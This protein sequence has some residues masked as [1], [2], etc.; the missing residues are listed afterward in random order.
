MTSRGKQA[1]LSAANAVVSIPVPKE[2][3]LAQGR[4]FWLEQRPQENGRTTLMG[5]GSRGR[6]PRDLTPGQW[7]L[8][9]RIHG[10][11]GGSYTVN[12]KI[13]VFVHDGDRC[14][15]R[16]D[17]ESGLEPGLE[18]VALGQPRQLT[19]PGEQGERT[20]S[21]GLID[22]ARD[23]WIGVMEQGGEDFWVAVPLEGGEPKT[24]HRPADFCGY[25]VLSP[26]GTHL[27][28]IEWQQPHMSWERSSLWL[29][30]FDTDGSLAD[31]R[32]IAGSD[33]TS[34]VPISVFQ[35]L[36]AGDD[37]VVA[38]D[39]SGW[40]NLE[41]LRDAE[42]LAIGAEP[43]WQP[44]LPMEAEFGAPQWVHGL[45]TT[46]WDGQQLVAAACRQGQWEL[47]KVPVGPET[48]PGEVHGP[49]VPAAWQPLSLPL[50]DIAGICAENGTLVAI[51]SGPTAPAGRLEVNLHNLNWSHTPTESAVA[52]RRD[53]QLPQALW[54]EGAS[55]QPTQA[56]FHPPEGGRHPG[57]P[58]L[59]RGHSGPT[60]VAR[61]GLS[62]AI[63]FWTSR[64]WGVLDV[65]YGGST[66]FG[67]AYRQRLDG[68]WGVV[69][70]ADLIAAAQA[71]LAE[72]WAD[73]QRV[74]T[75]GGSAAGFTVLSALAQTETFKAGACRYPVTDLA[76]MVKVGHRF[77]AHY[78]DG[79]VGPWPE[80]RDV[81]W[82]R[83]PLNLVERIRTPLILFHGLQDDVVPASQSERLALELTRRGMPVELHLFADEGHGFRASA[84]Q[85][86][87]LE[88]T[89]AFFRRHLK[90]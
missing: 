17:L 49:S 12:G 2:P 65:N 85:A 69:D 28:W 81:Y 27:A 25:P 43:H 67:R 61:T 56:W 51:A 9:S 55:G 11:G 46:A 57:A 58:L 7:N 15:W 18:V 29:G 37:L 36:W 82:S 33:G 26:S 19:A 21:D 34:P 84:V 35:P 38:N 70:V 59:V 88:A 52:P 41:I 44:L 14:L 63:Q 31:I 39:R 6:P 8:R 79:L 50:N 68:Q 45:R 87:V 47:G 20:F 72:G 30:R 3:L 32:P 1:P 77:E 10:Y 13:A 23:R 48:S 86:Q 22:R 5:C 53:Q 80:A 90:L 89:E 16:L 64:G 62:A 74:A 83:S 73:P 60:G 76:D 54:F 40:W 75:E 71:V 24:L 78:L 42:H 4:L 66:G